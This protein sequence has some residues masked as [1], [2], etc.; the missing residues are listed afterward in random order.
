MCHKRLDVI[1]PRFLYSDVGLATRRGVAVRLWGVGTSGQNAIMSIPAHSEKLSDSTGPAQ[2]GSCGLLQFRPDVPRELCARYWRDVHGP[3]VARAPGIYEYRQH[4]FAVEGAVDLLSGDSCSVR[5]DGVS[6]GTIHQP[7]RALLSPVHRLLRQDERNLFSRIEQYFVTKKGFRR[8]ELVP[9]VGDGP[10]CTEPSRTV[11]FFRRRENAATEHFRSRVLRDMETAFL[12]NRQ[13][14][15]VC[16]Y[17]FHEY[18]RPIFRSPGISYGLTSEPRYMGALILSADSR[19]ELD[20][21][22]LAEL[23]EKGELREFCDA[24]HVFPVER[25]YQLVRAGE[26][27]LAGKY[28]V[29]NSEIVAKIHEGVS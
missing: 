3:L 15:E 29:S 20:R 4:L 21:A 2:L 26:V 25:T 14:R 28:G 6:E 27:T 5:P 17:S 13:I 22:V 11:I 8:S 10:S 12:V 1:V 9:V 23:S 18:R 16:R 7:L 19:D 24:I